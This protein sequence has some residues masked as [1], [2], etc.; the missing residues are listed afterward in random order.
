M[1]HPQNADRSWRVQRTLPAS[2]I[3]N[4]RDLDELAGIAGVENLEVGDGTVTITYDPRTITL[5]T[6]LA[7]VDFDLGG[8]SVLARLRWTIACYRESVQREDLKYVGGWDNI[9]QRIYVTH[10]ARREAGR[11][12]LRRR[13]W[14]RSEIR[15]TVHA[16]DPAPPK[17]TNDG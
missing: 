11:L 13:Q 5:E 16:E 6:I 10:N 14:A 4:D 17:E 15:R 9:V 2:A 7:A 1:K 8:L 12:E 3:G